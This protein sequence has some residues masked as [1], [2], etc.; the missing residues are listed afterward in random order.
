M[1][2]S[3]KPVAYYLHSVQN[4]NTHPQPV[5]E[6]HNKMIPQI[7]SQAAVNDAISQVYVS[8]GL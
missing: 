6:K 5:H 7:V 1:D 8:H 3:N 4:I 2:N